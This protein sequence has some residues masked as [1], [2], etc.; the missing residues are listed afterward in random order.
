V[1]RTR[2]KEACFSFHVPVC[3][4]LPNKRLKPAAR[5][6]LNDTF[7]FGAPQPKRDPLARTR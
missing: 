4:V 6:T 3:R 1:D 5:R 2:T 7:F